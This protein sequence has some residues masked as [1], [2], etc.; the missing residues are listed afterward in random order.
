MCSKCRKVKYFIAPFPYRAVPR[1]NDNTGGRYAKKEQESQATEDSIV[2][3]MQTLLGE[4]AV[5]RLVNQAYMD[6]RT[7]NL[8]MR[9]DS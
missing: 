7:N 8:S 1:R 6:I 5:K 9:Y 4:E 3:F 2:D